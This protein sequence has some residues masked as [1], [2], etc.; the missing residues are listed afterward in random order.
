MSDSK[1]S[2]LTTKTNIELTDYLVLVDNTASPIETKKTTVANFLLSLRL[3]QGESGSDTVSAE[4]TKSFLFSADI[5]TATDGSDYDLIITCVDALN[6]TEII[7]YEITNRTEAGFD[8]TP[9]SDAIITFTALL[10]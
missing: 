10:I 6:A 3:R 2:A 4:S 9:I 5:G 7:G 1:I 8:I